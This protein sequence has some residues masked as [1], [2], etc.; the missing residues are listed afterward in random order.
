MTTSAADAL[1]AAHSRADLDDR[2]GGHRDHR[3]VDRPGHSA[4]AR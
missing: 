3:E 1:R 2:R 4:E